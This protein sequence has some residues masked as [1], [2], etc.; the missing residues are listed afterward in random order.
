MS[1]KDFAAKEGVYRYRCCVYELGQGIYTL[2]LTDEM[3]SSSVSAG[4]L[5]H[6]LAEW[7]KRNPDLSLLS[8]T[9]FDRDH[10]PALL[11]ATENRSA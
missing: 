10:F 9:R 6:A 5:P 3:G 7:L 1:L 8:M 2:T 4:R 11:V